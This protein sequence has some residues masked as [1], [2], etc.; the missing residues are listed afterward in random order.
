M[1]KCIFIEDTSTGLYLSYDAATD[2]PLW[3]VGTGTATCFSEDAAAVTLAIL[4]AGL[5]T[6]VYV[7]RP[8]DR[9]GK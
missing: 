2:T 3:V 4:N 5:T 6:N 8:G 9:G 7:G 1:S